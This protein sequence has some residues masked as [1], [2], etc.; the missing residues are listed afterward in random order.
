M[1]GFSQSPNFYLKKKAFLLGVHFASELTDTPKLFCCSFSKRWNN[2]TVT[3]ICV[4]MQ[5]HDSSLPFYFLK[6]FKK[7]LRD[8]SQSLTALHI[9]FGETTGAKYQTITPN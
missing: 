4:S 9:P 6:R 8:Q 7:V 2:Y 5:N 1:N 3:V